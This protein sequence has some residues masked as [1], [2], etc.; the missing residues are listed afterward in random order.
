MT[1]P[2]DIRVLLDLPYGG[3][4]R[5]QV[6]LFVPIAA[7]GA[8]VLLRFAGGWWRD[9]TDRRPL[10]PW[11]LELAA[12]G[13]AVALIDTRGIAAAAANLRTDAIA[14]ARL[15]AEEAAI[16]DADPIRLLLAG[17]HGGAWLA[18]DAAAELAAEDERTISTV[19]LAG[20][21]ARC[22]AWSGCPAERAADLGALSDAGFDP[23][24]AA[25][26]CACPI[27]V[28]ALSDEA[29][30]P[31]S[32]QEALTTALRDA[33]LTVQSRTASDPDRAFADWIA[34]R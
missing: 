18:L 22:T 30:P 23:I 5:Q 10:R 21:P 25:Q 8:P 1:D 7:A 34:A 12:R 13:Q 32:E 28:F 29:A 15:A 33:G 17:A 3:H 2:A 9:E 27:T 31:S 24:A 16:L 19:A 4:E 6:D 14:G 11:A 20:V 26:R